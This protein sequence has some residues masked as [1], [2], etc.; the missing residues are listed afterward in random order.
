[1]RSISTWTSGRTASR[2]KA[3]TWGSSTP[4]CRP[5]G[6]C[7][8]ARQRER[9]DEAETGAPAREVRDR[10]RLEQNLEV[11]GLPALERRAVAR[12]K[13]DRRRRRRAHR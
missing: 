8:G 11:G 4:F 3:A 6:T 5:C 12:R 13:Y 7:D 9:V 1:M 2:V 10:T